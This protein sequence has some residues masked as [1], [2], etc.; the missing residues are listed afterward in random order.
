[1]NETREVQLQLIK[2]NIVGNYLSYLKMLIEQEVV[3]INER[4]E[5]GST[6]AHK[7]KHCGQLL[8]SSQDVDR[9]R[10]C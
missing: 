2:V 8:E 7:G 1:M 10:S 5:R 9:A 4:D 6:P 3:N